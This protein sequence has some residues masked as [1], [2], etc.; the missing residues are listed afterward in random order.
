MAR[1]SSNMLPKGIV[2][3]FRRLLTP[4]KKT[5]ISGAAFGA[6]VARHRKAFLVAGGVAAALCY[7]V[8]KS[9][10]AASVLNKMKW[11]RF[12]DVEIDPPP[13]GTP[14]LEALGPAGLVEHSGLF[15]GES[16]AAELHG[17][18]VFKRVT[19]SRFLNGDEF[20]PDN[21]RCGTKIFAACDMETKKPLALESA[22]DFASN[23]IDEKTEYNLLTNNCHRFTASCLLGKA[24]E[25]LT[26]PD[27]L[28]HGAYSIAC[29]EEVIVEKVNGGRDMCW[30]SVRRSVPSFDFVVS[31]TR[32]NGKGK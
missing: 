1:I 11:K 8:V 7:L 4:I 3:E 19:L 21:P 9:G 14:L 29:L 5:G 13:P 28:I 27:L 23:K 12:S 10:L 24:L 6:F 22:V 32:G 30:L 20:D 18:G 16:T 31:A 17:D 25:P 2:E 15:L 26:Y